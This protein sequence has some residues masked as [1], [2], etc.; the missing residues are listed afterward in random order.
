MLFPFFSCDSLTLSLSL[1]LFLASAVHGRSATA[2]A[3][4]AQGVA[5]Q[6]TKALRPIA[7]KQSKILQCTVKKN[8]TKRLS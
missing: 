4:V 2:S 6:C 7:T 1:F 3:D 5:K 8:Y